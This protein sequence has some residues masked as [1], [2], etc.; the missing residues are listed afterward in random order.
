MPS[1]WGKKNDLP[2]YD[3][4]RTGLTYQDVLEMVKVS[5][6]HKQRGRGSVLGLFHEIKLQLYYQAVDAGYEGDEA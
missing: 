1:S 2:G 3:K 5:K 6:K 4:F